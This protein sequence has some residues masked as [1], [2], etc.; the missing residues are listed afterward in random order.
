M[1][2]DRQ[3]VLNN[4]GS[5]RTH[6]ERVQIVNRWQT[7]FAI[8]RIL[9]L[10]CLI[11][12]MIVIFRLA[13]AWDTTL[14]AA[15]CMLTAA[16]LVYAALRYWRSHIMMGRLRKK[17]PE[18]WECEG[19]CAE[20]ECIRRLEHECG[21][22]SKK[23]MI[24]G[25]IL[26]LL[27]LCALWM[28]QTMYGYVANSRVKSFNSNAKSVYNAVTTWQSEMKALDKDLPLETGIY[29]IS[30]EMTPDE[31]SVAY[32]IHR[33]F[34][35]GDYWCAIVCDDEGEILYTFFSAEKITEDELVPM[36][37]EQQRE[38]EANLFTRGEVVGWYG[39]TGG[40]TY[41]REQSAKYNGR[42]LVGRS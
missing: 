12:V 4:D 8:E 40:M 14:G 31:D 29:Y 3:N 42:Y 15:C 41:G 37:A 25:V 11:A 26:F 18:I 33:Y 1:D 27:M 20:C 6:Y 22:F 5:D 39:S 35:S 38:I 19:G 28:L 32:N 24:C 21:Q 34:H 7:V 9:S 2:R 16:A 23:R 17:H 30:A 13:D 36:S 10:L